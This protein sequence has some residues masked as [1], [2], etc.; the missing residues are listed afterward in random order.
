[1][2]SLSWKNLTKRKFHTFLTLATVAV[3]IAVLFSSLILSKGV[4]DG[5]QSSLNRMGADI[6]VLPVKE[7]DNMLPPSM[8]GKPESIEQVLF[9]GEPVN[10]Y[11][12]KKVTA[13]IKKVPGVQAVSAQFFTQTLNES[14]CSLGGANR[15]VG[16]D[17]DS[18][19][20]I[21]PWLQQHLKGTLGRDQVITGGFAPAPLGEKVTI[22]GQL[23]TIVDRL[24]PVGGS[25]DT[26]IFIPIDR[27]RELAANSPYLKGVF[28]D[29]KPKDLI[30]DVMVKVDNPK[31]AREV[32][33]QINQIEGVN[34]NLSSEVMRTSKEQLATLILIITSLGVALWLVCILG[35]TSR[36]ATF[37]MERKK[38]VGL[39]RAIGAQ[40]T[41]IF[42]LV[43]GEALL[44]TFTGGLAGIALGSLL[45]Y[46]GIDLVKTRTTY[47][48]LLPGWGYIIMLAVLTLLSSLV[49]GF[50]ASWY[51]AYRCSRMDP[52]LAISEGE[53]E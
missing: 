3:A 43:L 21:K 11:M 12:D 42:R 2:Y 35:L 51:P 28:P 37:I 17:Q 18:D 32:A 50:L 40:R 39:L 6:I 36:F 25:V 10:S 7:G 23:F 22:L 48:F 46:K 53:L 49:I 33:R 31:K 19:F 34:A 5:I 30:S 26:T 27:A 13:E 38:E 16:F 9:T 8:G 24:D 44:T 52:V 45:L 14:C 1:M 4:L 15:L 20:V 29:K 47:P 41:D